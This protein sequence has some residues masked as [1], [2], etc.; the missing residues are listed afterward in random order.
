MR[1][2]IEGL[3]RVGKSAIL[4]KVA[5]H[6]GA[7]SIK[8]NYRPKTE[9]DSAGV[10]E[11][12]QYIANLTDVDDR[13]FV[14]DRFHLSEFVYCA[15]RGYEIPSTL[16]GDFEWDHMG[17]GKTLLVYITANEEI[18]K[19][20]FAAVGEDYVNPEEVEMLMARYEKFYKLSE[21]TNKI[22][23]VNNT[24]EDQDKN[25]KKIIAMVDLLLGAEL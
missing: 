14:L 5:K 10:F 3:D 24:Y 13:I 17:T 21:L 20:R 7:I 25:I 9:E 2:I 18:V 15:K 16:L 8:N 12:Y 23:L 1:I 6:Y 19:E 11:M 4:E 22:R